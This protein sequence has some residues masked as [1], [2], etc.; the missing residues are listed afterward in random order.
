MLG[1]APR[2]QLSELV[3]WLEPGSQKVKTSQEPEESAYGPLGLLDG[4]TLSWLLQVPP[5]GASFAPVILS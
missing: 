5:L 4:T 1:Q 2:V 3:P